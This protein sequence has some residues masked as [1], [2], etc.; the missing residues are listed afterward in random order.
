MENA[1]Y[2]FVHRPIYALTA[3]ILLSCSCLYLVT[4]RAWRLFIPCSCDSVNDWAAAP[5]APA[6][7]PPPPPPP[8][9][10]SPMMCWYMIL[11]KSENRATLPVCTRI[12]KHDCTR[13]CVRV[14]TAIS[15]IAVHD[16]PF[17]THHKRNN[18]IHQNVNK[19]HIYYNY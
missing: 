9:P 17:K 7:P 11:Q 2:S 19:N 5:V 4:V 3:E 13:A 1:P 10:A 16:Q 14:L 18:Y 15:T 6:P 8:P 12:L